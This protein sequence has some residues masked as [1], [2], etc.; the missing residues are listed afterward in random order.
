MFLIKNQLLLIA[1]IIN[2]LELDTDIFCVFYLPAALI[3]CLLAF[4]LRWLWRRELDNLEISSIS[5]NQYEIA[6]LADG[7][8]RVVDM[9]FINLVRQGYLH[10]YPNSGKI[11]VTRKIPNKCNLLEKAVYRKYGVISETIE[12]EEGISEIQSKLQNFGLIF[13]ET[14]AKL[15]IRWLSTIPIFIM[16]LLG[17]CKTVIDA[18]ENQLFALIGIVCVIVTIIACF[19]LSKPH[20]TKYGDRYLNELQKHH[21]KLKKIEVLNRLS[22]SRNKEF[23]DIKI[24]TETNT[25]SD[26]IALAFALF[27]KEVLF[28]KPFQLVTLA[29]NPPRSEIDESRIFKF[30]HR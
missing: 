20:R 28:A 1:Q 4:S 29:F 21:I 5:L 12:I 25:K 2:P 30:H 11:E 22:S 3:F 19:F 23:F 24:N 27:G 15:V 13:Q 10:V 16:A 7:L 18:I 9:A 6:Y 17:F 26:K 14:Q 8:S